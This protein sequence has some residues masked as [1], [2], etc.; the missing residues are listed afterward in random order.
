MARVDRAARRGVGAPAHK[1]AGRAASLPVE[2]SRWSGFLPTLLAITSTWTV[3]S[4]FLIGE[5]SP[6]DPDPLSGRAA[7]RSLLARLRE[8]RLARNWS[9]AELARRAGISRASYQNLETG[10]GNP[11]LVSL[12]RVLDVL[13]FAGRLADL[14]PEVES[15]RTLESITGPV[16]Q[17]ARTPAAQRGA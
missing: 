14:V 8:Q 2:V 13:G 9:Q 3:F 15:V 11:T 1:G 16:R 5:M 17:R 4:P 7:V 6:R 12:V 10:Y